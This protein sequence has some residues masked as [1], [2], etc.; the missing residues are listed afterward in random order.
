[1]S[2]ISEHTRA[3][4]ET[5]NPQPERWDG[6]SRP[7]PL[8]EALPNTPDP[9]HGVSGL[10]IAAALVGVIAAVVGAWHFV[11]AALKGAPL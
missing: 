4:R 8:D 6:T 1:M 9:A 11:A 10:G 7:A 5:Y 2:P 3:M